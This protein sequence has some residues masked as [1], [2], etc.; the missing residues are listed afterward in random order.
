MEL[1]DHIGDYFAGRWTWEDFPPE[2][3]PWLLHFYRNA[4]ARLAGAGKPNSPIRMAERATDV[5]LTLVNLGVR[6]D[7][8]DQRLASE[9]PE[10]QLAGART[11]AAKHFKVE[12]K[13]K[14]LKR[15]HGR[16]MRGDKK[17]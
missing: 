7:H 15:T 9:D 5:I 8:L 2:L 10:K 12:K 11:V 14:S 1:M 17:H 3:R 16:R 6:L 13:R 4:I